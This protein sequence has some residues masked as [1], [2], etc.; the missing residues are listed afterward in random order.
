MFDRL[1][2]FGYEHYIRFDFL[3]NRVNCYHMYT[4]IGIITNLQISNITKDTIGQVG[5]SDTIYNTSS[6][7][8]T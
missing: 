3:I 8:H 7:P 6:P 4:E 1:L 5:G 2:Y